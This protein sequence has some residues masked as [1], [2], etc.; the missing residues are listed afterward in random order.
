MDTL[1]AKLEQAKSLVKKMEVSAAI[2]EAYNLKCGTIT[3][4]K[5]KPSGATFNELTK[6]EVRIYAED[7][8][9]LV[10]DSLP[11]FNRLVHKT[12]TNDTPGKRS[13]YDN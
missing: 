2:R 3:V 8:S 13:K 10:E 7:G 12:E 5:I 9:L 6:H 1:I 4:K 11:N